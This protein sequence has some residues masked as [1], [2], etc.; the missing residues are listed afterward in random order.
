MSDWDR[1]VREHGPGIF[2]AAKRI[3][4]QAADAEDVVQEVLIEAFRGEQ[5]RSIRIEGGIL[6]R[7]AVCRA[8]DR[9]RQR[10]VVAPLHPQSVRD[11]GPGP[12][13]AAMARELSERLRQALVQLPPREAEVFSLRYFEDLAY[14]EIADLLGIQAGAVATALHKARVKLE[15]LLGEVVKGA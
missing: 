12:A 4:G 15:A 7:M 11:F 13:T 9:L 3:L 1:I 6:R 14:Q 2:A 10:K 8:L 5:V